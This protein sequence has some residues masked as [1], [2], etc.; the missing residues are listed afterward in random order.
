[1]NIDINVPD[2][3]SGIY[4]IET[5]TVTEEQASHESMRSIFSSTSRP[6]GPGT[7][8]RLMRGRTVMMSNTPMEIR[9]HIGFINKA[10]GDVL[11]NGLGLGMCLTAI[12]KKPEVQTVTVIELS[13]DVINLV[14][15]TFGNDRVSIIQA[16]AMTYKAPKGKRY[17]AVWH[18][19]W[20]YIT[21][22]NLSQMGKLHL[23]Y[24]GRC[25][26]QG[27]WGKELCQRQQRQEKRYINVF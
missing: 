1:M 15:P 11:I 9:D 3:V 24:G 12:L 20:D 21:P 25:D 6:I 18:D 10:C 4:K 19:I 16:D 2:G 26:W 8:K 5:F 13:Q 22:D 23:K 7:Y 14:G 17:N 27:S